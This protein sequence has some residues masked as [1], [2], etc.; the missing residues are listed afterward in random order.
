LAT[1]FRS[2]TFGKAPWR[3]PVSDLHPGVPRGAVTLCEDPYTAPEEEEEEGGLAASEQSDGV[4]ERPFD[5][6]P[7]RRTST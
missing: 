7:Q 1:V 6:A 3:P 2:G 5:P 4:Y